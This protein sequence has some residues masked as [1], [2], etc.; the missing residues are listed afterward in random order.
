MRYA[1]ATLALTTLLTGCIADQKNRQEGGDPVQQPII[2]VHT[3]PAQTVDTSKVE[4]KVGEEA[5]KLQTQVNTSLKTT[6]DQI[7]GLFN[8]K[9][10]ELSELVKLTANIDTKI[11]A[12]AQAELTAKLESQIKVMTELKAHFEANVNVSNDMRADLKANVKA[13]SDINVKLGQMT[14]QVDATVAGQAGVNNTI[15]KRFE[16]ITAHN[17]S[18]LPRE[19]VDTIEGS[20]KLVIGILILVKAIALAALGYAYRH[21][22]LR[23]QNNAKLLMKAI[24]EMAPEKAAAIHKDF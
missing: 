16:T 14:A 21:A 3:P 19:A 10:S 24:G 9:I 7:S 20:Y 13:L 1:L 5:A 22:R 23:E 11:E 12:K 2:N 17:V 6:Q 8:A 4:G 15:E 18:M